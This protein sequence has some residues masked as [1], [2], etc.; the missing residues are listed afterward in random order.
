MKMVMEVR[1]R[2]WSSQCQRAKEAAWL[3]GAST[4]WQ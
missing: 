3:Y 2:R 1:R 4:R